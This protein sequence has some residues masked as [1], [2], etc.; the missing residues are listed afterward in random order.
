MV[1]FSH[2]VRVPSPEVGENETHQSLFDW[3]V[4]QR[5]SFRLLRAG[6]G[7]RTH[8]ILLGKQTLCQLSYTRTLEDYKREA[9]SRQS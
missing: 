6:D 3:C 1:C 5:R 7:I 2:K 8:D 4:G 9:G